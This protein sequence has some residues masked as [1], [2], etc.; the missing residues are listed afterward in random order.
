MGDPSMPK[1]Y[2]QLA[3]KTVLEWSLAQLLARQE[4]AGV[5]V[6]LSADD[7]Q[8]ATLEVSRDPRVRSVIGGAERALSVHEGLRSLRLDDSA[9]VM[10]HDAARPC[11]SAEEVD[12][13][14]QTLSGDPVGGLLAAPVVDTLKRTDET[15][16]VEE[17]VRRE[18][19]WR[20]L[21]PQM[22]RYGILYRA[23]QQAQDRGVV[24]TDE[25]QAVE[26]LGLRPRVVAGSPDN[27]K[28]TLPEDLRRAERILM[29][30]GNAHS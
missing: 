6:A 21:T 2:L 15:G 23:L 14:L 5:V 8:W 29:E 28:I 4:C 25:A 17:T 27:I 11:L 19:L 10:V 1:Q 16:R 18:R 30:Q 26:G 24:V 12:S 13:L 7:Q 9:W 20:A 22:F 3:G